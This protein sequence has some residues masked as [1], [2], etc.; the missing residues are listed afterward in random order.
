MDMTIEH[1]TDVNFRGINV[2]TLPRKLPRSGRVIV[3]N[4]VE[5]TKDMPCGAGG[6]RAWTQRPDE[7]VVECPCGWSGLPHYRLTG[8]DSGECI[9]GTYAEFMRKKMRK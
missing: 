5:H 7:R 9:P 1:L 8:I 3:H 4:Q 2:G 6:F